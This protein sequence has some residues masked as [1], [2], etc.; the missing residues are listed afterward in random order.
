KAGKDTFRAAYRRRARAATPKKLF[1]DARSQLTPRKQVSQLFLLSIQVS[2]GCGVRFHFGR[3]SLGD[4]YVGCLKRRHFLGVVGQQPDGFYVQRFE[5]F[6]R[7]LKLAMICF[8]AKLL[9][10]WTV[11]SPWSCSS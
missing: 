1:P 4:S 9:L 8:E 6:C 7:K 2:F 5:N 3:Y 10:A 11:S